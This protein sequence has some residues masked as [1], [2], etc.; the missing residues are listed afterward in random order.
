MADGGVGVTH[1]ANTR[2]LLK[3]AP[4]PSPK[5]KQTDSNGGSRRGKTLPGPLGE[6]TRLDKGEGAAV[7][8]QIR[9]LPHVVG[10]WA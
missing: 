5:G 3:P 8:G 9:L 7:E 10:A 1:S 6:S 2:L 4:P